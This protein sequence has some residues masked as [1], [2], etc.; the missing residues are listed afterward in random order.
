MNS[1]RRQF[2]RLAPGIVALPAVPRLAWADAYPAH[3]VRI[4]VGFAAGSTTDTLA[5]LIGQWLS[6]RL[7]QQFVIENRPG[8]GGNVGAEAVIRST[9]DG[10]TLLMVPP[11]VAAN[12]A[13][14]PHLNFDFIRDVEPVAGVVR[15]PNV[16]EVN[17]SVPVKSVA[18]LIAYAKANPG[19]LSFASAGIGTASHL[20]GQLFN[21]MTGANLTHV[22]YR[23][24]GPAM[25]DLVADQVQVGFAT[26]TASIG[27]IRAGKLQP[28][29]VTT[30]T[31]SPALPEVPTVAETV[32]G[33]E[34]S[35][36]FGVAAPKGTPTNVV[37]LLNRQINAG[38]ADPTIKAR[39]ADMG[40]M[41]LTG[42][43]ADFG[44]LIASETDK[45]GKV[46]RE[47]GIEA[48]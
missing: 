40:G 48:D 23:G 37:A 36:W 21:K 13:L 8:A 32:P 39:L 43:P 5:R 10:Y 27:F 34:A 30:T 24:D 12:A 41:L 33:F 38:L 45:W 15:V 14:Y 1:N 26:M 46:I 44:K 25:A 4:I 18:E 22:P 42:S 35:S 29:A 7:G 31:R 6:Q 20:A 47:A 28:L 3:A 9:P 17:P 2:L 19:K 11:A 16:V